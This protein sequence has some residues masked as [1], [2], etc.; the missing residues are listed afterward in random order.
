MHAAVAVVAA[1]AEI[2]FC[3]WNTSSVTGMYY[4][5]KVEPVRAATPSLV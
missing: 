4:C 2:S 1:A 3:T 5:R